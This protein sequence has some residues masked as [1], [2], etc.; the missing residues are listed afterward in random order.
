MPDA[1]WTIVG[2]VDE[3]RQKPLQEIMCGTM[4]IAL[5]YQNGSFAAISGICNHA[6]GPLGEGTLDGDFVVCP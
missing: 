6:G 1:E 5:T 3:L 4:L 2:N